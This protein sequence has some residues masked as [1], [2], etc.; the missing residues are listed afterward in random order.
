MTGTRRRIL[1]LFKEEEEG[2]STAHDVSKVEDKDPETP[3]YLSGDRV[4]RYNGDFQAWMRPPWLALD[5]VTRTRAANT[6]DCAYCLLA[7]YHCLHP[8][9]L[10]ATRCV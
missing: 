9:L 2:I 4:R 5:S 10:T 7:C 3:G 6:W 1:H 8:C